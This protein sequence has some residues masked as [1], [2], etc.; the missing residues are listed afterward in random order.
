[1]TERLADMTR[2]E[3]LEMMVDSYL[4]DIHYDLSQ[5]EMRQYLR[6]DETGFRL[7]MA[8]FMRAAFAIGMVSG[9]KDPEGCKEQFRD[10]G[11]KF[12]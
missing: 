2:T 7:L 1:V 6:D 8:A 5:I 9:V 4:Q 10:L 3:K 11:Y 12:E